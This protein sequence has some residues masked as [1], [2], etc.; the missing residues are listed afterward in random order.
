M[1]ELKKKLVVI[2]ISIKNLQKN[3]IKNFEWIV[4]KI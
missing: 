2:I 4:S 1:F 3:S